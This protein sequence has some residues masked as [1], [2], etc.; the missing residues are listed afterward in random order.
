MADLNAYRHIIE[1]TLLE[2]T[3]IPYAYG[4]IQTEAVFDRA[5]DRYLLVNVGWD[6]GQRVHG[7]LVH[8]DIIDDKIW[9]QRDGTEEGIAKE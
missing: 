9:I 6:R 1:E 7:S 4:D 5:N 3:R 8:I 2:Y